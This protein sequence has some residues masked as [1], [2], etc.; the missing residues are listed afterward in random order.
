MNKALKV[1]KAG[2]LRIGEMEIPCFVLDDEKRTRAISGRGMTKAIG[3]KGR[4]QG[5]GRIS[6]Q[7]N[8]FP[9]V[10]NELRVAI[11]TPFP[12]IGTTSRKANPTVLYEGTTLHDLC[13]AILLA[14]D[15][16]ALKTEQ[17]K[18]YAIFAEAAIRSFSKVGIIAL[19]DEATGYQYERERYELQKILKAYISEELL[20]WTAR[21]PMPFYREM[22]RLWGWKFPPTNDKGA[23]R[24]PRYS[25]KLTRKLIFEQL[26]PGVLAELDKRNPPNAKWQRKHRFSQ[27][28]TMDIGNP[29]LEQQVAVV[30][31]L[32][33]ISP[34][35]RIFERNFSRAFPPAL[36]GPEK[37]GEFEF[38]KE[39]EE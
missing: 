7:K 3:M 35:K 18:R 27:L 15:A 10:S 38:M 9:F 20:P 34:N 21:F 13:E 17:E 25:G 24:G 28:L 36:P 1:L 11:G 39:A 14:R 16:G 12:A 23:P 4:G 26:P 29:H 19:I 5:I 2:K 33:K 6:T 22:Y 37:Q 8:I 30:T 31:T 32:M